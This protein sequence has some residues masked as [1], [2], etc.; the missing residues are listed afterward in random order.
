M[1]GCKPDLKRVVARSPVPWPMPL[2]SIADTP[3]VEPPMPTY[4]TSGATGAF[5]MPGP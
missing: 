5:T 3:G 1:F 2:R 4:M